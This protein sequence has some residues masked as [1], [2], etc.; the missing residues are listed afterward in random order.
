[1]ISRLVK[2][3]NEELLLFLSNESSEMWWLIGS[4]ICDGCVTNRL[5][6]KEISFFVKDKDYA[7][8]TF[9]LLPKR[10]IKLRKRIDTHFGKSQLYGWGYSI[11]EEN[12]LRLSKLSV[13][14]RKSGKE[15]L[16]ACSSNFF[17]DLLRGIVEADGGF[18][19]VSK[20]RYRSF[21]PYRMNICS[22][23]KDFLYSIQE[24]IK[25]ETRVSTSLKISSVGKKCYAF[26]YGTKDSFLLHNYLY[27]SGLE[28]TLSLNRK[29]YL[30]LYFGLNDK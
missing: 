15:F 30:S 5:S 16:P 28:D 26:T 25:K 1:M 22:S 6:R 14:P 27:Y 17:P 2:R 29:R 10:K 19:L 24:R 12:F 21:F 18:S 4:L 20:M 11:N 9:N 3:T 13:F 8:K 23:S 7:E